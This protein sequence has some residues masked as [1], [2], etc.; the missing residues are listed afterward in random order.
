MYVMPELTEEYR[1]QLA[2]TARVQLNAERIAAAEKNNT[3]L[4]AEID[5]KLASLDDIY[6]LNEVSE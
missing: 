3:D 5:T 6:L 4:V 2:E 1:R